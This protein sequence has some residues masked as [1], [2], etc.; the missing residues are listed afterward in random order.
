MSNQLSEK[1]RILKEDGENGFIPYIMAGD[2][3]SSKA[4]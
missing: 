2:G 1:L 3:R 4:A